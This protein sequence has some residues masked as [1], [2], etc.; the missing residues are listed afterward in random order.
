MS[1]GERLDDPPDEPIV[2]CSMDLV[3]GERCDPETFGPCYGDYVCL[4]VTVRCVEG[5]TVVDERSFCPYSC[6][7]Y[8]TNYGT[9]GVDCVVDAP[10]PYGGFGLD[11]VDCTRGEIVRCVDGV[12][13]VVGAFG[14]APPPECAP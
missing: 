10:Y 14:D 12:V 7:D 9:P 3:G 6:E 4:S 1:E 5:R 11:C 2:T 13:T 8:L